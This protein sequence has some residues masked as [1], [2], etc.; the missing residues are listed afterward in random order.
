MKYVISAYS[1]DVVVC[2]SIF[3]ECIDAARESK[4]PYILTGSL[5]GIA[6]K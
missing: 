3:I 5:N 6:G 4:V 2:D 1:T